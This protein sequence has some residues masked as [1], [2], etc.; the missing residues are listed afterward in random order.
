MPRSARRA[1]PPGSRGRSARRSR[2]SAPARPPSTPLLAFRAAH[3][4]DEGAHLGGVLAARLALD[5]GRHVDAP[6]QHV[7]DPLDG[8]ADAARVKPAREDH[9]VA[10]ADQHAGVGPVPGLAL[11]AAVGRVVEQQDRARIAGRGLLVGAAQ[12]LDGGQVDLLDVLG[13]LVAVELDAFDLDAAQHPLDLAPRRVAE[14]GDPLHLT[15]DARRDGIRLRELERTGAA[16]YEVQSDQVGARVHR[17][18][19][20][21]GTGDAA[22][23]DPDVHDLPRSSA[24]ARPTS[25]SRIKASPTSTAS[26]P[27]TSSRRTSACVKMPLSATTTIP[28]PARRRAGRSLV[29]RPVSNV[30]RAR[31][32][33]PTRSAP[34]ARAASSSASSCT[35]TSASRPS[36]AARSRSAPS[37]SGAS[38]R[39]IS[40]TASA[41]WAR[42]S[43]TW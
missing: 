9:V 32:L 26:A 31:L 17:R 2:R 41:P 12:R 15:R 3:R 4:L 16:R 21:V 23:L 11:A 1:P 18:L 36:T 37:A 34:A 29:A 19:G 40:N 13:R 35:S 6:G 38:A 20:V 5:P 27:A 43:S 10:L 22:D 28:R 30:A 33:M 42:A 14:D 8:G 24:R 7:A 25:G 39:A